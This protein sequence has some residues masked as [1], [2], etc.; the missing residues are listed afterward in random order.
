MATENVTVVERLP[1]NHTQSVILSS[2]KV[3]EE[4]KM[5]IEEYFILTQ[6]YVS[7][8]IRRNDN[9][10]GILIDYDIKLSRIKD[11]ISSLT[12]WE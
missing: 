5:L 10:R 4:I 11:K 8:T 1:S 12:G 7:I 3:K 9:D 2:N 6:Q